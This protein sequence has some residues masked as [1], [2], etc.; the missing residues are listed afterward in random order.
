MAIIKTVKDANTGDTCNVLRELS[1]R[2][3]SK[4]W[5]TSE[6]GQGNCQF[7]DG[8]AIPNI[9]PADELTVV[10]K[11]GSNYLLATHEFGYT[12]RVCDTHINP[13][14]PYNA[15]KTGTKEKKEITPEERLALA[16]RKA[17][18]AKKM[19][20]AAQKEIEEMEEAAELAAIV[21]ETEAESTETEGDPRTEAEEL[22]A[23]ANDSD[24]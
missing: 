2:D 8:T 4:G 16:Q 17:A 13:D 10:E 22:M 5:A 12:V 23:E 21:A 20:E 6:R 19:A 18:H 9:T 3:L 14:N 15:N 24:S 1:V 7:D 11:D